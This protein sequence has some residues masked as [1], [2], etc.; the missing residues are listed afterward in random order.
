M[1]IVFEFLFRMILAMVVTLVA[2]IIVRGF[3]RQ[4]YTDDAYQP[5][6]YSPVW[7][8]HKVGD[9]VYVEGSQITDKVTADIQIIK[10]VL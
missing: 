8:S 3:D 1:K 4:Y 2:Y 6:I 10:E 5:Y 9:T 7:E